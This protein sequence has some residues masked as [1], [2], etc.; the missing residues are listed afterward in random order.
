MIT[1]DSV[2]ASDCNKAF[3]VS[4]ELTLKRSAYQ[5]ELGMAG[6]TRT[7]PCNIHFGAPPYPSLRRSPF[8]K[9]LMRSRPDLMPATL[10]R[11]YIMYEFVMP[12]DV[13]KL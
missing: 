5:R 7:S 10:S 2:T 13:K 8:R 12:F 4:S 9:L 11:L 1:R 3:A 6:E